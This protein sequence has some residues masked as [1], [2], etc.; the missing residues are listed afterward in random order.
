MSANESRARGRGAG[1]QSRLR[2][3]YLRRLIVPLF[4]GK[5]AAEYTARGAMFG[6]AIAFTP[7]V[8][9][10]MPIVLAVWVVVRAM[11]PRYDFSLVVGLA[12]TWVSN[13]FTVPPIYYTFLVTGQLM[14]GRF[15]EVGSLSAF[16]TALDS[17]AGEAD[18]WLASLW[19]GTVALFEAFG[20]PMFVGCVPWMFVMGWVGYKFSLAVITK[21]RARRAARERRR[22]GLDSAPQQS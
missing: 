1:W 7:L 20:V 10:Q 6:L 18:S 14:L 15:D 9:V 19:A 3:I 12:Y 8:G 21:V 2:Q 11:A 17:A 16:V 4:R 13:V 22:R 5:H